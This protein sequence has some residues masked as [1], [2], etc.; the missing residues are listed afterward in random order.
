M[1]V[2]VDVSTVRICA[3]GL[4]RAGRIV[5]IVNERL[6]K[7]DTKTQ[8]A[9]ARCRD[10]ALARAAATIGYGAAV[11]IEQ[12]M[13]RHVRSVA[14]V[15]R[16]VGAFIANLSPSTSACLIGV[17]SWKAEAGMPGNAG[18]PAIAEFVLGRYPELAGH[19][20]DILDAC[21][22]ALAALN[23]SRKATA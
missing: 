10:A 21:G 22:V 3:V 13:G 18:K 5:L 11:W 23:I 17:T 12:P 15:E 14:T 8:D 20:Q 4:G 1:I 7:I 9:A 19:P 6:S 16:V 2:G